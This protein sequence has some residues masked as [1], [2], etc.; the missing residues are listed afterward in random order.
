MQLHQQHINVR[1]SVMCVAIYLALTRCA[2]RMLQ[3]YTADERSPQ[4]PLLQIASAQ[5][6]CVS[7]L[8]V[9][10]YVLYPHVAFNHMIIFV[11]L[12][13]LVVHFC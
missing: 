10:S 2:Q 5:L 13:L 3:V 9:Q 4:Y 7:P 1:C 8:V 11:V 6:Q 12:L